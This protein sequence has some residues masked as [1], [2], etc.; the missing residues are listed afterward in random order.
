MDTYKCDIYGFVYNESNETIK[1]KDL[2]E[3][4]V[5][6]ICGVNKGSFSKE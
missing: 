6:P 4:W 2:P 1:F 3:D 5:C